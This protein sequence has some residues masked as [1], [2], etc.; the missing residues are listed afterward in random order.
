MGVQVD[1]DLPHKYAKAFENDKLSYISF[2]SS[3]ENSS[4]VSILPCVEKAL[5]YCDE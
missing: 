4:N 3:L 5:E 2:F 1:Q